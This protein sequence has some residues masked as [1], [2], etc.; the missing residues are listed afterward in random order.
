MTLTD[1]LEVGVRLA[2]QS[3]TDGENLDLV[4]SAGV[5]ILE[6]DVRLCGEGRRALASV[7]P[8]VRHLELLLTRVHIALPRDVQALLDRF[9]ILDYRA[10]GFRSLV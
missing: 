1:G 6:S 5:E 2:T 3:V 4:A 7:V 9:Q 10:R 8:V